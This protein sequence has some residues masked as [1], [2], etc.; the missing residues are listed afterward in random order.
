MLILKI[1]LGLLG[2]GVVVFVHELGHFLAARAMGIDVEVFSIGWGKPL[3]AKKIGA[4]EYRL[5]MF[6]IGGYCKMRG[7]NEF[8][9]AYNNNRNKI[10]PVKGSFFGTKPW[11]RIVTVFAGPF[12][13]LVFAALV[14]SVIWGVGFEVRTMENRIVLASDVTGEVPGFPANIAGLQ[15]GD[16]ITA[17]NGVATPTYTD[18][19]QN[20]ALNA[21]KTLTL[22]VERDGAAM[23]LSITPSLEKSTGAGKIGVYYW[24]D[25]VIDGVVSSGAASAAGLMNGDRIVSI[26]GV[27]VP[28]SVAIIPL[29]QDHPQNLSIV[30]ERNGETMTAGLTPIYTE[31]G[32]DVGFEF[33]ALEYH[34]PRLSPVAA[35]GKG[36][37]EAWKTLAV[38]VQSLGLL[39][40]GIDLTQA[41]SGPVR[42][43]YMLGD[44]AA[45]GFTS[46]FADGLRCCLCRFWTAGLFCSSL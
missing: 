26:N 41:V 13:N 45:S 35:V 30:F 12:F 9:E 16:R 23:E 17:I 37:S 18:I 28:Y 29:L 19:Q 32:A 21:D 6:P 33:K 25:P 20:I 2:L 43:T 14:F 10:E 22:A 44:F 5:G 39:F 7:D 27:S 36:M 38:S 34:T 42:I 8:E 3:I 1:L 31:Q 11:R 4:V 24:A 46:S 40:K 15:S